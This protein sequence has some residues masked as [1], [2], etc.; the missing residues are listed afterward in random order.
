M[1]D[2]PLENIS[3][4][5][6]DQF[7]SST[8]AKSKFTAS[9]YYR[10]LKAAFNKAV[11]WNYIKENPFNKIKPPKV[12]KSY[13][14]FINFNELEII[15]SNTEKKFLTVLFTTAFFSGMRLAELVNMKWSWINFQNNIITVKCDESFTT[16]NRKERIVPLNLTLRGIL[17]NYKP[18]IISINYDDFVFS[19]LKGIRLNEDF[20]SKHFKKAVRKSGLS[21]KIH[22]HSLRHSFC[23][24]LVQ[25]GASLY[26]VKELAGHAD[27]RMAQNY[28]HLLPEN[29]HNAVNLL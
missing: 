12:K 16:K 4:R 11:T 25:K 15:N 9:L 10:T 8:A 24:N 22:F 26:I 23:S 19:V 29:L 3:T 27:M 7:I 1:T 18:N 5:N 28:S 13:P 21:D 20:V 2:I 17:L 6:V 14:A